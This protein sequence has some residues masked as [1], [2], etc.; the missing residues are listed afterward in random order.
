MGDQV[1]LLDFSDE[2]A[3]INTTVTDFTINFTN[4]YEVPKSHDSLIPIVDDPNLSTSQLILKQ[5]PIELS[6]QKFQEL[7]I[8]SIESY[9]SVFF[10]ILPSKRVDILAIK[11]ELLK[12]SVTITASG[13]LKVN[14]VETGLKFFSFAEVDNT[15]AFSHTS[16]HGTNLLI[17][18]LAQVI[19]MNTTGE[20]SAIVKVA[21]ILTTGNG[22]NYPNNL[23][24]D[25][26]SVIAKQFI[27]VLVSALTKI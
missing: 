4:N 24:A 21:T 14:N 25:I 16:L 19:H 1:N 8:S 17:I 27:D 18:V 23:S 13:P 3:T 7:W 9:N 2:V 26:R 10:S 6:P 12:Y 22:N 11:N 5:K 20:F 15:H